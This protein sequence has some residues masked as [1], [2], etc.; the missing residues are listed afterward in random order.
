M[1]S[2]LIRPPGAGPRL[3]KSIISMALS[4]PV[5]L[6]LQPSVHEPSSS[7]GRSF[8][9]APTVIIFLPLPGVPMVAEEEPELPAEKIWINS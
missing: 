8:S 9:E 2:G 6:M 4:A 7:E 1:I 3:E 5:E